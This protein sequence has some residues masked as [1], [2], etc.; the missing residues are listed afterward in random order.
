M[1]GFSASPAHL[2]GAIIS[3]VRSR[4]CLSIHEGT[5]GCYTKIHPAIPAMACLPLHIFCSDPAYLLHRFLPNAPTVLSVCPEMG[6]AVGTAFR[7]SRFASLFLF[8]PCGP[9]HG[10]SRSN[11]QILF[12]LD[13]A[14]TLL[15]LDQREI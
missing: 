2:Q 3:T 7:E 4:P 9:G 14:R 8:P 6:P 1:K 15:F 11:G 5:I 12:A 10:V 13:I